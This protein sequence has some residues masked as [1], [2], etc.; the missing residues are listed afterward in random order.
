[1]PSC[2]SLSFRPAQVQCPDRVGVTY[3][4]FCQGILNVLVA[5]PVSVASSPDKEFLPTPFTSAKRTIDRREKG[6]PELYAQNVF[7]SISWFYILPFW[8]LCLSS[9]ALCLLSRSLSPLRVGYHAPRASS[10]GSSLA[11]D[12]ERPDYIRDRPSSC[13]QSVRQFVIPSKTQS[14]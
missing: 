9:P 5:L 10:R 4:D 3:G 11:L 14:Q 6:Y 2:H 8:S 7:M 1:V 12:H 13:R